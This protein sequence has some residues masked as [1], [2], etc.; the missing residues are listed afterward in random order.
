VSDA[1]LRQALAE[2]V[3]AKDLPHV[4][5]L[6]FAAAI[7]ATALERAGMTAVLVGGGAIEFYAPKSYTTADIDFVVQGAT[8]ERLAPVFESLGLTRKDRHWF[9]E[10]L[11]VEVPGNWVEDPFERYELGPYQLRIVRKEIVLGQRIV[12]FRYWKTWA[13]GLQAISM[14]RAFGHELDEQVLRT[15]LRRDQAEEAYELLRN[16][17]ASETEYAEQ[18]LDRIWHSRYR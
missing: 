2:T 10:D 3:A 15:F 4:E 13:Y 14:I 16:L 12:G 6:T 8:R 9:I 18:D 5:R 11:Y 17:A 1:D 7:I